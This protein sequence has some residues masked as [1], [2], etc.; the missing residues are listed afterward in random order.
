MA[1]R[2]ANYDPLNPTE[3]SDHITLAELLDYAKILYY[4]T[5]NELMV[6]GLPDKQKWRIL[7][8]MKNSGSSPGFQTL[9]S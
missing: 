3:E 2:K 1:R 7:N 8:K 5:P 6:K 4:H 9:L